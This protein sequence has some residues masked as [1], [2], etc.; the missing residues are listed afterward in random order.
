MYAEDVRQEKLLF[1]Q[2]CHD[3]WDPQLVRSRPPKPEDAVHRI[4]VEIARRVGSDAEPKLDTVVGKGNGIACED[5]ANRAS[6]IR[7]APITACGV[8]G[9]RVIGTKGVMALAGGR[10][11]VGT[12]HPCV[13]CACVDQQPHG[14]SFRAK[15]H[16]QEI[17]EI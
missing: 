3:S 16:V 2:N 4:V 15:L 6:T 11:T 10:G 12:H 1:S 7:D 17:R 8:Q 5:T 13:G 14:R 9:C